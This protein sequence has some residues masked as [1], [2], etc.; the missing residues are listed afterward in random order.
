MTMAERKKQL[1]NRHVFSDDELE[2]PVSN[3]F[4]FN[5]MF[6]VN[7]NGPQ[8]YIVVMFTIKIYTFYVCY[9]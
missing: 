9:T 8:T 3:L 5:I 7:L 6:I 4:L 2:I 1:P